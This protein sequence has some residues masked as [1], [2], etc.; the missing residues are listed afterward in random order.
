MLLRGLV[1]TTCGPCG[2]IAAGCQATRNQTSRQRSFSQ[3]SNIRLRRSRGRSR[4]RSNRLLQCPRISI[5]SIIINTPTYPLHNRFT[6][7]WLTDRLRL[8]NFPPIQLG[9][10]WGPLVSMRHSKDLDC[11]KMMFRFIS[12]YQL[13]LC[14][15]NNNKCNS[16]NLNCLP[17]HRNQLWYRRIHQLVLRVL[18]SHQTCCQTSRIINNC[19]KN[20]RPSL[21]STREFRACI[22]SPSSN[23]ETSIAIHT[24]PGF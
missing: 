7:I 24:R 4:G 13:R 10:T 19:S 20:Y 16:S 14:R 3:A 8:N 22:R 12:R 1:T 23:T 9:T 5:R 6:L 11:D 2:R 21:G 15:P 17:Y 18:R